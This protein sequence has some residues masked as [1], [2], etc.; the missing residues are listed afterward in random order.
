MLYANE[1]WLM[2][3]FKEILRLTFNFL[4]NSITI[5]YKSAKTLKSS[6]FHYRPLNHT[7][8]NKAINCKIHKNQN[9]IQKNTHIPTTQ[10]R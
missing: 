4:S 7:T 2:N 5:N 6:R 10:I 1:K 3:H 9:N 8:D